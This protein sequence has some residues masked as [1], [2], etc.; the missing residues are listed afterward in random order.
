VAVRFHN[1]DATPAPATRFAFLTMQTR[2]LMADRQ[3]SKHSGRAA[4]LS[5]NS[6][7]TEVDG[8]KRLPYNITNRKN[9]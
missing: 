8:S 6:P 7:I 5:V 1:H 2:T 4:T 3:K 9:R